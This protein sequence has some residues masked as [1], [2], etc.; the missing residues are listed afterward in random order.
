M[1]SKRI[2]ITEHR[3]I[4]RDYLSTQWFEAP[5]NSTPY[6]AKDSP[7]CYCHDIRNFELTVNTMQLLWMPRDIGRIR[8]EGVETIVLMSFVA[9]RGLGDQVSTLRLGRVSSLLPLPTSTCWCFQRE[10]WALPVL[11]QAPTTIDNQWVY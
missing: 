7:N 5:V 6:G 10:I 4:Q 2:Q 3:I 11:L 1:D 9:S 8:R